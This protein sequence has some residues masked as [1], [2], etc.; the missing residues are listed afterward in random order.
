[1]SG[2]YKKERYEAQ[3]IDDPGWALLD[4]EGCTIAILETEAMADALASVLDGVEVVL[5]IQGGI[6][7]DAMVNI[8]NIAICAVDWDVQNDEEDHTYAK[9]MLGSEQQDLHAWCYEVNMMQKDAPRS[10]PCDIEIMAD[11]FYRT[12]DS[13]HYRPKPSH[14]VD[15]SA[16]YAAAVWTVDDVQT[17]AQEMGLDLSDEEAEAFLSSIESDIRDRMIERGWDVIET[18]LP[19]REQE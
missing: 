16:K 19:M 1:M 4:S 10:E 11:V 9:R 12:T 15:M 14:P 6:L 17:K 18:L 3:Y 2:P 7:H 5:N 8:R 13:P